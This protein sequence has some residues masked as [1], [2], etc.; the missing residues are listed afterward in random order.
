MR[1]EPFADTS[2][3]VVLPPVRTVSGPG[4]AREPRQPQILIRTG[5]R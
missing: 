5:G 2:T 1:R 4:V 3:H